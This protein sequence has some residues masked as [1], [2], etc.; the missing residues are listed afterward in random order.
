MNKE[1]RKPLNWDDFEDLCKMIWKYEYKCDDII[2]NGRSG[3][4]QHGVDVSGYYKNVDGYFGIQCKG[5][6][7]YDE[8]KI[9]T[10]EEVANE[11][12]KAKT[13]EP[14]LK[15]F[16]FT[17]TANKDAKIERYIRQKDVESRKQGLF[18][19]SLF[20]WEDLTD[21]IN[22]HKAVYDYYVV[23]KLHS[24]SYS[25]DVKIDDNPCMKDTPYIVRPKY[26]DKTIKHLY[27][28]NPLEQKRDNFYFQIDKKNPVI[29]AVTAITGTPIKENCVEIELN[30]SN[31]GSGAFTN[32]NYGFTVVNVNLLFDGPPSL[33]S[34]LIRDVEFK[35]IL[36]HINT[37]ITY[38]NK[39]YLEF[40]EKL[41]SIN[42][43]PKYVEIDWYFTSNEH[44]RISSGKLYVRVD[45]L[46]V[47]KEFIHYDALPGEE[48]VENYIE[49]YYEKSN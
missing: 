18:S 1:I 11:I 17:T 23:G 44:T 40:P 29:S 27:R 15:K 8:T 48:S 39:I 47:K 42:E 38:S 21:L 5:K 32:C 45:P 36:N 30:I 7:A 26:I 35:G 25:I 37:G 46:I 14:E 12:E 41:D 31:V 22:H 10:V 33:V 43:L 6:Y 16:I 28:P 9:L 24:S 49:A 34:N 2:R 3:Q 20:S 13:F 4:A 19:I